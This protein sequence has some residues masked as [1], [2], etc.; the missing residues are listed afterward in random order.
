MQ[1]TLSSRAQT[2]QRIKQLYEGTLAKFNENKTNIE[3]LLSMDST[4]EE[5]KKIL[6]ECKETELAEFE[7]RIAG[8]DPVYK[9]MQQ[10]YDTLANQIGDY[11]ELLKD[12]D[13]KVCSDFIA[14]LATMQEKLSQ[15]RHAITDMDS[16]ID[17]MRVKIGE[18]D[19]HQATQDYLS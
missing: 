12:C 17:L 18:L 16:A 1:S 15:I 19:I 3:G 13:L 6:Q 9:K 14:R 7:T 2:M 8:F 5:R 4:K 10:T 11:G